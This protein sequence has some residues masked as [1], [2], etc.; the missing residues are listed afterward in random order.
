[1]PP[2]LEA[3]DLTKHYGS[4]IA[5]E[6]VNFQVDGG[7]TGLL[8][9]NGA[10]KSTA[11]KLFLGLIRP[12]S[13]S[14]EVMG[15]RPYESVE[16][17]GR[18]G[19]MPE[20]DCLPR[21]TTASEFLTHMAQVSGL[22]PAH[23]RTRTADM[24]RHVGLDEERYRPIGEYSAGMAQRVKLAQAL[25]HDPVLAL[26]DEPTAGLDPAGR[27]EMLVLIR[28]TGKEFGISIVLSSHL[29]GDVERTCDRVIVLDGGSV[30]EQ[31]EVSQFT[32]ETQTIY[33]DVD[34]HRDELRAALGR[35]GIEVTI[36]GASVVVDLEEEEQYDSIRDAIVEAD[37][38][39]RRMA[40]R[41]HT[42]TEIFR[43]EAD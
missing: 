22:P 23:A 24:L 28:R 40:P 11:I 18:L 7:I 13:G 1:M 19:Y 43:S 27:E 35:R 31:G 21:S 4:T 38:R 16:I 30:M 8:G 26:L 39:L 33:I 10:G 2:L 20:H 12:T 5:L 36:E 17:R 14:A 42:L 3:K 25:V 32:R 15:V 37:A 9:P 29:M 41:R 34:D 6:S